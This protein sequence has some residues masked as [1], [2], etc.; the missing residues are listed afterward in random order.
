MMQSP[1]DTARRAARADLLW[2]PRRFWLRIR[3]RSKLYLAIYALL[4]PTVLGMALF[5][6]YPKLTVVKYSFYRW[7][8]STTEEFR[9]LRNFFDAFNDPIFWQTF[10]VVGILL[11]ANLLKMWPSI[12]TA[13]A[14]HRIRNERWKYLYRVLFVVPMVIPGLVWLLIWKSF[15]DPNVGILNVLLRGTGLMHVLH[16]LDRTMPKLAYVM[17][18]SRIILVDNLFGSVW[19][20]IVVGAVWLSALAGWRAIR[21]AWIWWVVLLAAAGLI[22][23]TKPI[24][25]AM[26]P[27]LIALALALRQRG[28][29]CMSTAQWIGQSA[30]V[31]ACLY[32]FTTMIWTVPTEA[33]ETGA[34]A[35]LGHSKLILPAVM[36]WGFPYVGTFGV[37]LYLAGLANI[38]QDVYEAAELDG[39]GSLA[40]IWHIELPLILGQIRINLIFL[41][42][43]TLLD[44]GFFLI[45]L[46]PD[47]G[48]GNVGLVPGLYM[49]TE[50][51]VQS[52]YGYACTLGMVMFIMILA[53]TMIYQKYLK[54]EQ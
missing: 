54:V 24:Y 3:A 12:I 20:L 48:P 32:I 8:V 41:T 9:G 37:L 39:A 46:G 52:R 28:D 25:L 2:K 21:R 33:F 31:V 4:L 44:Y 17:I 7:D 27:P 16:W 38:S 10:R 53:L 23:Q 11:A 15:Y 6:Y 5:N 18:P 26:L 36:F 30:L 13:I 19:G 43:G 45:L 40:R 22:W 34:P 35:W 42:I 1:A 51:F 47:G 50:A 14:I 29:I 49:Y